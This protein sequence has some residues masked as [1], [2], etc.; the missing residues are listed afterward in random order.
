MIFDIIEKGNVIILSDLKFE[1]QKEN[2]N[3]RFKRFLSHTIWSLKRKKQWHQ[4][5]RKL[6]VPGYIF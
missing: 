3:H 1:V 5:F 2:Q 6:L 4:K